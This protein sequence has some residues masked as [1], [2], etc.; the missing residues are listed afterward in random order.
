MKTLNNDVM[1]SSRGNF[2]KDVEGTWKLIVDPN[3]NF[4]VQNASFT[5]EKLSKPSVEVTTFNVITKGGLRYARQGKLTFSGNIKKNYEDID[6][7]VKD[8][9]ELRQEVKQKMEAILLPGS[10]II[11][12]SSEKPIRTTI[13]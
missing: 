9:L 3:S 8:N 6:I 13:K 1:L 2:G 4:F 11:N 7:S 12:F 5:N 10:E